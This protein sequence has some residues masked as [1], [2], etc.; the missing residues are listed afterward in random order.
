MI[1]L[2]LTRAASFVDLQ[3]MFE[4]ASENC[5]K[6]FKPKAVAAAKSRPEL[7]ALFPKESDP[8]SVEA[9]LLQLAPMAKVAGS[10]PP[11]CILEAVGRL[12]LRHIKWLQCYKPN[13]VSAGERRGIEPSMQQKWR[14]CT[15]SA[16]LNTLTA[17][18]TG[19]TPQTH[20]SRPDL[21]ARDGVYRQVSDRTHIRVRYNING[22]NASAPSDA[23]A[24]R[25]THA[26][27]HTPSDLLGC[28]ARSHGASDAELA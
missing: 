22:G 28:G 26:T 1:T 10:H 17:A 9:I 23:G 16:E 19:S 8:A 5:W 27:L 24:Q 20:R 25:S 15:A 18:H 14:V 4:Y 6:H 13:A 21:R 11:H 2:P 12:A 7:R 3:R